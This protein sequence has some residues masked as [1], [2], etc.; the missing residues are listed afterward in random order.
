MT[1]EKRQI[2]QLADPNTI[3]LVLDGGIDAQIAERWLRK[4]APKAEQDQRVYDVLELPHL[5]ASMQVCAVFRS[6]E[7]PALAYS[8]TAQ[9]ALVSRPRPDAE[10]F[11]E[12]VVT[13]PVKVGDYWVRDNPRQPGKPDV[14]AFMQAL[15][16]AVRP[17]RLDYIDKGEQR[18]SV[19]KLRT[20]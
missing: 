9:G 11:A 1:I 17:Y 5:Q 19:L 6:P 18:P 4:N 20:L 7:T 12:M 13:E 16:T 10:T 15:N 8:E 14:S 3:V 2:E